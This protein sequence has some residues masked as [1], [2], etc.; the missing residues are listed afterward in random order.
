[1]FFFTMT[2]PCR[3]L[4]FGCPLCAHNY[5]PYLESQALIN[6]INI[7][8][9][10]IQKDTILSHLAKQLKSNKGSIS[11]PDGLLMLDAKRIILPKMAIKPIMQRLHIGHLDKKKLQDK[12]TNSTFGKE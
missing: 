5:V 12:Q 8:I 10:D 9:E 1:M 11:I 6:N 2:I 3:T 7:N 4:L